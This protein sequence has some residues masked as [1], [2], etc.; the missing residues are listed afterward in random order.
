LIAGR[1]NCQQIFS[2][3]LIDSGEPAPP[4]RSRRFCDVPGGVRIYFNSA[5]FN[6]GAVERLAPVQ[7][8]RSNWAEGALLNAVLAGL[9][10]TE[11]QFNIMGETTWP[12]P[13]AS[14]TS[15]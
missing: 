12:K 3:S 11:K 9:T 4:D 15:A 7:T 13:M 6:S 14:N 2:N 8:F 10:L 5:S 1:T